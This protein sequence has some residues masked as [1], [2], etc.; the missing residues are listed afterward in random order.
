MN[1]KNMI[2]N[3]NNVTEG[4][5]DFVVARIVNGE[6]W[7]YGRYETKERANDVA[8]EIGGIVLLD[9][10]HER[11]PERPEIIHE[12]GRKLTDFDLFMNFCPLCMKSLKE[13]K[14]D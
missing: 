3:V 11:E 6:A 13:N 7:Y 5:S 2:L 4:E 8:S 1:S 14:N 12:C 10:E 9:E